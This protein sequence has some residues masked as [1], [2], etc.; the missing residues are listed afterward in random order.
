MSS[1]PALPMPRMP[2]LPHHPARPQVNVKPPSAEYAMGQLAKALTGNAPAIG[3]CTEHGLIKPDGTCRELMVQVTDDP[4]LGGNLVPEIVANEVMSARERSSLMRNI[5]RRWPMESETDLVPTVPDDGG[6]QARVNKPAFEGGPIGGGRI[7]FGQARL[8][9]DSAYCY[10]P[11]SNKLLRGSAVNLGR[12]LLQQC[13][14]T[15]GDQLDYEVIAADGTDAQPNFGRLGLVNSIP[16]GGTIV[17]PS[18]NGGWYG[19]SKGLIIDLL[20][21]L[22]SRFDGSDPTLN[23][24]VLATAALPRWIMNRKFYAEYIDLL[25]EQGGTAFARTGPPQ[26]YGY[27]V[28]FSRHLSDDRDDLDAPVVLFGNFEE[29]VIIGERDAITLA[30]S[31]HVNFDDDTTLFQVKGD[32]DFSFVDIGDE[33]DAG[34]VVQLRTNSNAIPTNLPS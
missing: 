30:F 12:V 32:W 10:I 2:E 18:Q 7:Q 5:S 9:T 11:V 19:I 16:N 4:S 8:E 15:L 26:W 25:D 3:Y 17:S 21:L 34:G 33:T 1:A 20:G 24:E 6:P 31:G 22:P 14:A 23:A 27:P 29:S 28:H 13:T